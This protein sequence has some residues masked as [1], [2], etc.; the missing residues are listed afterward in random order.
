METTT[1]DINRTI[2]ASTLTIL[3]LPFSTIGEEVKEKKTLESNAS[4]QL[5]YRYELVDQDIESKDNAHASTIRA[6]FNYSTSLSDNFSGLIEVDSATYVG[7]DNFNNGRNGKV[8]YSTVPDYEYTDV[9]QAW[10][11]YSG[12]K[13]TN[14]KYGRQTIKLN[15]RRFISALGWRQ[16]NHSYTGALLQNKSLENTEITLA[17]I[18]DIHHGIRDTTIDTDSTL[19]NFVY[20]GLPNWKMAFYDI[21]LDSFGDT[22]GAWLTGSHSLKNI[23]VLFDYEYAKQKEHE[24]AQTAYEVDYERLVAG[25]QY[26]KTTVKI[27]QEVL[28]SDNANNSALYTPLGLNH[29]FNGWA[30]VFAGK[31]PEHGL[32]DSHIKLTTSLSGYTFSMAY[33]DFQADQSTPMGDYGTEFDMSLSTKINKNVGVLL[34]YANYKADDYAVDTQKF[35]VQLVS[36]NL[37]D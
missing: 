3:V 8:N 22:T 37:L 1:L 24:Q 28:G 10:I 6:R 12:F 11:N 20:T 21:R 4:L 36:N 25:L 16:N 32:V 34:K 5:R 23:K 9:N 14:L 30:D 33:H 2:W 31:T 26:G 35:W 15:N 7:N 18:S 13:D 17:Y 29:A 19:F 27:G